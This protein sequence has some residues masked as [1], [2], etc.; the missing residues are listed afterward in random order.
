M[1]E[2]HLFILVSFGLHRGATLYCQTL[3]KY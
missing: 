3:N 2:T 1:Y